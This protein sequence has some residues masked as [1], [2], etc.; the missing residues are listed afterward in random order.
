MARTDVQQKLDRLLMLL[1][2]RPGC[3]VK[4]LCTLLE[5]QP[6]SIYR[7]LDRLQNM[8]YSIELDKKHRY[9]LAQSAHSTSIQ[10][11]LEPQE[12]VYLCDVLQSLHDP[13]GLSLDLRTRLEQS[14]RPGA[15]ERQHFRAPVAYMLGVLREAMKD[16]KCVRLFGYRSSNSN[17]V[18]DRFVEPLHLS[19]AGGLFAAYE[20]E[21][22][23]VKTFKLSRAED[24]E[25]LDEDATYEGEFPLVDLFGWTGT[26]WE[27][28]EVSFSI[29]AANL[30]REEYYGVMPLLT[31]QDNPEFPVRAEIPVLNWTGIGRFLLGLPGHWHLHRPEVLKK[32]VKNQAA[33]H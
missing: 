18:S 29:Y 12:V 28:V 23:T 32:W 6:K 31:F 19:E 10:F 3:T 22:E 24:L 20:P 11:R 25:L 5:V 7:Y 33:I 14:L 1:A 27:T 8:G 13:D 9:L 16:R 4:Q 15:R 30:F 2:R 17:T 26:D 21:S